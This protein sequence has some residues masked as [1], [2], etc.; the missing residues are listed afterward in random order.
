MVINFAEH[1]LHQTKFYTGESCRT[2]YERLS[3]HLRYASSPNSASYKEEAF[4]VHYS[5]EHPDTVPD[6]VFDLLGC[7]SNTVLRKVY[8]AMYIYNSKSA[9]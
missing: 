7:E 4:A 3:E 9:L 5:T 2:L 8:E 1:R 6:L